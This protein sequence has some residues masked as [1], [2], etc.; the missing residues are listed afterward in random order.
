MKHYYLVILLLLLFVS[1]KKTNEAP[2]VSY[3][4]ME[5]GTDS[6]GVFTITDTVTLEQ[7]WNKALSKAGQSAVLE[8][9]KI[10]TVITDGPVKK[11]CFILVASESKGIIKVAS[12]LLKRN[13][14]F[15]FDPDNPANIICTGDCTNGCLPTAMTNASGVVRLVC[16]ACGDCEKSDVL[17]SFPIDN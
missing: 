6:N 3:H 4:E 13:N 7:E 14:S 11:E 12:L 10:V 1:C 5:I 9:F 17:L 15:Y 2:L 16:S 8:D